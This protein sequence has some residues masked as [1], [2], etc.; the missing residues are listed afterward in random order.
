VPHRNPDAVAAACIEILKG[1][2]QRCNGQWLREQAIANFGID[3]FQQ[4]LLSLVK[5]L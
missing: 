2:D 3:A 4:Q 1:D 5:S